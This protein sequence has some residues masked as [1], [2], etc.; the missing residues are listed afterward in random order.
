[1]GTVRAAEMRW[2][3]PTEGEVVWEDGANWSGGTYPSQES[4]SE[5]ESGDIAIIE[6]RL[7][8]DRVITTTGLLALGR[9]VW[10]NP[11]DSAGVNLLRLGGDFSLRDRGP[12]LSETLITLENATEDTSRM[13]LDLN[14]HV[15]DLS[16]GLDFAQTPPQLAITIRSSA[17]GGVL[18]IRSMTHQTSEAFTLE[19]GATL[20]VTSSHGVV[21]LAGAWEKDSTLRLQGN[22][23]F[24]I[25]EAPA[26]VWNVEIEGEH[27]ET[28]GGRDRVL[29]M[30][31][32]SKQPVVVGGKFEIINGL[33][34]GG[35]NWTAVG[36]N[37]PQYLSQQLWMQGDFL[38]YMGPD[39]E[40]Q[41]Y[42]RQINPET[43]EVIADGEIV[44]C[45]GADTPRRVHVA[46]TGMTQNFRVG[47]DAVLDAV[48]LEFTEDIP[49]SI[50]LEHDLATG[51][52]T[53][54]SG[55]PYQNI[56]GEPVGG[57]IELRKHSTLDIAGHSVR[58]AE[59]RVPPYAS[60]D[61]P[62]L[63]LR[64]GGTPGEARITVT[65]DSRLELNALHLEIEN[66][67]DFARPGDLVLFEYEGTL[68]GTPEIQTDKLPDG[69]RFDRIAT[70]GG[71][72]RLVNLRFQ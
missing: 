8:G 18:M 21:R 32:G 29:S 51:S 6:D 16:R 13:V 47:H 46:R 38:D 15:F 54:E 42:S 45:G 65:G 49:G 27:A 41:D 66:P 63:K 20:A 28:G 60:G 10:R 19:A 56:N 34:E 61:A 48:D 39:R 9:L 25:I 14:G 35:I 7:T 36:V 44:F 33:G 72:V 69:L 70:D 67:E 23:S 62:T 37:R 12:R 30:R 3:G 1:M 52:M 71:K 2:V 50:R 26:A 31:V 4:H 57:R 64:G 53:D 68:I 40:M 5:E 59:F 17:P 22:G 24:T 11:S 55:A 43:N 58:A